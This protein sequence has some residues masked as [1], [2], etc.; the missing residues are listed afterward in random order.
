M[1]L[2]VA[3]LA[4]ASDHAW[5]LSSPQQRTGSRLP[6]SVEGAVFTHRQV[7]AFLTKVGARPHEQLFMVGTMR[8]MTV[9]AIFADGRVFPEERPPLFGVAGVADVVDGIG[10]QQGTGRRAVRVVA[11]DAGHLAF[12]QR[13]VRTLSEFGTLLLVTL[14]SS[15]GDALP[16]Q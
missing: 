7:V 1:D 5:T 2:R 9:D 6:L 3:V 4:R 13:H 16:G 10:V 15:L 14:G 12:G 11:V 8:L